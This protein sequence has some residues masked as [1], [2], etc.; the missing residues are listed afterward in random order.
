MTRF[1]GHKT[2]FNPGGENDATP[3]MDGV[4]TKF[5]G[6]P[7]VP[8]GKMKVPNGLASID[9]GNRR[10]AKSRVGTGGDG[11]PVRGTNAFTRGKRK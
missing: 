9:D 7:H 8:A 5:G 3:M 4:K 2:G 1:C 10:L 6:R 11:T